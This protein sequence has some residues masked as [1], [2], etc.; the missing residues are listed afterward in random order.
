MAKK[1]LSVPVGLVNYYIP[2]HV[3]AEKAGQPEA[4]VKDLARATSE[5]PMKL[6][7]V[8]THWD[9]SFK[10]FPTAMY[11]EVVKIAL[12]YDVDLKTGEGRNGIRIHIVEE[13]TSKDPEQTA[14]IVQGCI[15]RSLGSIVGSV[16]EETGLRGSLARLS[17]KFDEMEIGDADGAIVDR[18]HDAQRKLEDAMTVAAAF[19]LTEEYEELRSAVT[20]SIEAELVA[21]RTTLETKAA[22]RIKARV[23]ATK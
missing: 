7:R 6:R 14:V 13:W 4:V 23:G 3:A 10:I 12:K 5:L 1:T 16:D 18:V 21:S 15:A 11:K 8:S 17:K 9:G 20:A 19:A 22:E 2:S